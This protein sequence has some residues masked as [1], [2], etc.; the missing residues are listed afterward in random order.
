MN[1]KIIRYGENKRGLGIISL[2]E[3]IESAPIV[4]LLNAGLL[5]RSEPY[6]LNTRIARE[7]A[8]I[9]YI[10]V[11]VDL[12]G[13]GDTPARENLTNR[14]SVWKDWQALRDVLNQQ[15]G[16]R[17]LVIFGLCSGA[18]N[19]IKI[20][21]QDSQVVS[22]ILLDPVAVR[23]KDFAKRQFLQRIRNP[24]KWLNL[25][26]TGLRYLKRLMFGVKVSD[27]IALRDE[28]TIED[29]QTC[30]RRLV[31]SQGRVLTVF[32]SH[33]LKNY[34]KSGQYSEALKVEG[35][36][37]IC[38]EIFWP[39]VLHLYPAAAHRERLITVVRAW[40]K[41]HIEAIGKAGAAE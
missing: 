9:G 2:P 34:N 25:P 3:G 5:H 7:L 15:F 1:E 8:K 10:C 37:G 31:A 28:P 23:D 41:R 13:K 19:G 33:E 35:L 26:R 27:Y 38:E 6:G 20:A 14:E 29:M 36:A 18:D 22:L 32:T 39:R 11:R 30:Y 21:A 4:V 16:K 17:A 40:A 12:S 24:S